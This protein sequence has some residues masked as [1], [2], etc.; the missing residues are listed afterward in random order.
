[1]PPTPSPITAGPPDR[2]PSRGAPFRVTPRPR[3]RPAAGRRW[4]SDSST[5]RPS[6][7]AGPAAAYTRWPP[8]PTSSRSGNRAVARSQLPE[9]PATARRLTQGQRS[10]LPNDDRVLSFPQHALP[11]SP[12]NYFGPGNH[13]DDWRADYNPKRPFARR[14]GGC[15]GVA[16]STHPLGQGIRTRTGAGAS[17]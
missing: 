16:R 15:A 6:S 3:P 1:M 12:W 5:F 13:L 8:D 9:S 11:E 10:G 14:E 7:S 17:P 4:K 2:S